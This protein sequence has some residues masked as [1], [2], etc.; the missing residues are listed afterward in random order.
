MKQKS[1]VFKVLREKNEVALL[2]TSLLFLHRS[3]VGISPK[4]AGTNHL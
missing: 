2:F 3:N 1:K 4:C